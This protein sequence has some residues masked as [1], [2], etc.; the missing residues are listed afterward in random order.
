MRQTLFAIVLSALAVAAGCSKSTPSVSKP[1]PSPSPVGSPLDVLFL[2]G[3]S[4]GACNDVAAFALPNLASIG[5]PFAVTGYCAGAFTADASGNLYAMET[6]AAGQGTVYEFA[7]GST[8]S[9]QPQSGLCFPQVPGSGFIAFDDSSG[10]FYIAA[11]TSKSNDLIQQYRVGS[12]APL[13]TLA[14]PNGNTGG[15][16]TWP[17][18]GFDAADSVWTGFNANDA[19]ITGIAPAQAFVTAEFSKSASAT[20]PSHKVAA[21]APTADIVSDPAG[22]V[23]I[24][25]QFLPSYSITPTPFYFKAGACTFDSTSPVSGDD[26][27]FLL[28]QQYT[29]GKLTQELFG[30]PNPDAA[31]GLHDENAIEMAVDTT[32]IDYVS[33]DYAVGGKSGVLVYDQAAGA[34]GPDGVPVLCPDL[35]H[36]IVQA[37]ASLPSLGVD[38]AN[39]LYVSDAAAGTV[40]QYA[41]G[42]QSQTGQVTGFASFYPNPGGFG[43]ILVRTVR[44]NFPLYFPAPGSRR[45]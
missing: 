32:G 23:W 27:R 42:G 20:M 30:S 16:V 7:L 37:V 18:I 4:A 12:N 10:T 28:A 9:T 31:S 39:N 34:A 17:R 22:G 11:C 1:T 44:V 3:A 33:F 8:T 43:Q 40:T 38:S 2:S 24:L 6:N 41:P 25:R 35:N 13:R 14:E 21:Q 29:A 26:I 36:T 15:L 45:R 5:S 19:T